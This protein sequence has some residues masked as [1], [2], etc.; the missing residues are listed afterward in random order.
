[1]PYVEFDDALTHYRWDGAETRP[2]L[3][4]ANS[5]GTALAMWDP[6]IAAW[7]ERFHVLRYDMRGHG[8]S[9][10]LPGPYTVEQLAGD[11]L[12][13]LDKL[14]IERAHFCGLS[15][16]GMVAMWLAV[17]VPQ[18]I[19]RLILCNTAAMIPP[20]EV[21]DARIEAVNQGGMQA[22]TQAVLERWFTPAFRDRDPA[23][24]DRVRAM[25][26][27]TDP[28]GYVA[29]CAAVRDNDQREA[30][31]GIAAPTLVIAGTHDPSTPPAQ[32]RFLVDRIPGARY[33][34]LP[35]AHLSNIEAP[36]PFDA[37]V[38]DFLTA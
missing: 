31:R 12:A 15:L 7:S 20:P 36:A 1:M 6:Q 13:L 16:G 18:R 35:A 32:A 29:A 22:V 11:A 14:R 2:T 34:E 9:T 5:L 21:W 23:A 10:V 4:L 30:V 25:L 28:R 27:G 37:A 33:V 38:L 17:H 24:V 19:D 3:V 8:A 26:L